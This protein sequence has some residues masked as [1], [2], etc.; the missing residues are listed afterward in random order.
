MPSNT[1]TIICLTLTLLICGCSESDVAQ[2]NAPGT[3]AVS[4][5][6]PSSAVADSNH[7]SLL[8]PDAGINQ[9]LEIPHGFQPPEVD[10]PGAHPMLFG[11]GEILVPVVRFNSGGNAEEV[12]LLGFVDALGLKS[13]LSKTNT[14]KVV[15]LADDASDVQVVAIEAP[16]VTVQQGDTRSELNLFELPG[17]RNPTTVF[18]VAGKKFGGQDVCG[19]GAAHV[20]SLPFGGPGANGEPNFPTLPG[21]HVLENAPV[22]FPGLHNGETPGDPVGAFGLDRTSEH[23]ILPPELPGFDGGPKAGLP[24]LPESEPLPNSPESEPLPNS[25]HENGNPPTLTLEQE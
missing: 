22:A 9:P 10:L 17:F 18:D 5:A 1:W 24:N 15:R 19:L 3:A 13:L 11:G 16:A 6:L 8:P 2:I 23:S 4:A 14:L 25:P 7:A 12:Q 20:P 21:A